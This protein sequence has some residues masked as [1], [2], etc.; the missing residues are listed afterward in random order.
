MS[1]YKILEEFN[2]DYFFSKPQEIDV[3]LVEVCADFD[4]DGDIVALLSALQIISRV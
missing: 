1:K 4:E 2:I 3:F